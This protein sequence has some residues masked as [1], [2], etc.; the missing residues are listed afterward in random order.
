MS[1]KVTYTSFALK[2]DAY[3]RPTLFPVSH[4]Q[5]FFMD[6]MWV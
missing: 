2:D 5:R 1:V 6:P 3:Y 4:I